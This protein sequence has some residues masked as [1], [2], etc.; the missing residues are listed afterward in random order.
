VKIAEDPVAAPDDCPRLPLDEDAEGVGISG[1]NGFDDTT[2]LR[3]VPETGVGP[4]R[5][6]RGVDRSASCVG[7]ARRAMLP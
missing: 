1:K 3:V 7:V 4:L 5:V 6:A 2:G